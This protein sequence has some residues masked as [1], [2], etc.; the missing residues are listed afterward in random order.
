MKERK[1]WN[2]VP[3]VPSVWRRSSSVP[4]HQE[5]DE[6]AGQPREDPQIRE[7]SAAENSGEGE[8][9]TDGVTPDQ[10]LRLGETDADT[11]RCDDIAIA[12]S[13]RHSLDASA[14]VT[15]NSL[16]NSVPR[17]LSSPPRRR[18]EFVVEGIPDIS[19]S[20][21][22]D[23]VTSA[24]ETC[25]QVVEQPAAPIMDT[26]VT[27]TGAAAVTTTTIVVGEDLEMPSPDG[28]YEIL[29]TVIPVNLTPS[30]GVQVTLLSQEPTKKSPNISCINVVSINTAAHQENP[31]ASPR[32]SS[33]IMEVSDF[34]QDTCTPPP[35]PSSPDCTA[36]SFQDS[37]TANPSLGAPSPD[38]ATPPCQDTSA[39][40]T[41]TNPSTIT[42]SL[43]MQLTDHSGAGC[44][45]WE[46]ITEYSDYYDMT[47]VGPQRRKTNNEYED[48]QQGQSY[49]DPR[50][51]RSTLMRHHHRGLGT[52]RIRIRRAW[53]AVRG[54]MDEEK[55]RIGDAIR[56][57]AHA[58]A[59]R[60]V[61]DI[62]KDEDQKDPRIV[63]LRTQEGSRPSSRAGLRRSRHFPEVTFP[64]AILP[65]N[66]VEQSPS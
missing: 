58:Q 12:G 29:R 26:A 5:S 31:Y 54:W 53:R 30:D 61:Q 63:V 62:Q 37:S 59:V 8:A 56:R 18:K 28:D 47:P 50:R 19:F 22:N 38:C 20:F 45:D 60:Q 7:E 2:S 14:H 44:Q 27:A 41:I 57:H 17:A 4:P 36:P 55:V 32:N 23:S 35:N 3:R 24:S 48:V 6:Q 21:F 15:G 64:V 10:I 33:S 1:W 9:L 66:S 13:G 25:L 43:T 49:C 65:R 11:R 52:M 39:V 16:R 46:T 51:R 34:V 42:P 40:S